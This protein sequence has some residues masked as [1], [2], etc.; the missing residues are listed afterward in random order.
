ME[1]IAC[2]INKHFPDAKL[3]GRNYFV[4]CFKCGGGERHQKSLVIDSS[5][6]QYVCNRKNNCGVSGNIWTLRKELGILPEKKYVSKPQNR[7]KAIPKPIKKEIKTQEKEISFFKKRNINPDTVKFFKVSQDSYNEKP[8]ILFPYYYHGELVN[9][10]Y[11]LSG[12]RFAQEKDPFHTLWNLDTVVPSKDLYIVEGEADAMSMWQSG[13][14]NV[15]SVPSGVSNLNWIDNNWDELEDFDTIVLAL[16]N[17]NAGNEAVEKISLRLG[18]HRCKRMIFKGFKDANEACM[19]GYDKCLREVIEV[20]E[21]R[22]DPITKATGFED[23]IIFMR[24]DSEFDVGFKSGFDIRKSDGEFKGFRRGA[25]TIWTGFE[26]RGKTTMVFNEMCYQMTYNSC[27]VCIASLETHPASWLEKLTKQLRGQR[28]T[29]E[30]IKIILRWLND[31]LSIVNFRG[32]IDQELLFECMEYSAKRY[33]TDHFVIDNL[34]RINL[35][36]RD[37]YKGHKEFINKLCAFSQDYG[38]HVHLV[39]HQRKSY[40]GNETHPSVSGILGSSELANAVDNVF[41]VRKVTDE[42]RTE[43][44]GDYKAVLRV[45]KQRE[46]G[47]NIAIGMYYFV[48]SETFSRSMK[49]DKTVFMKKIGESLNGCN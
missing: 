38:V 35:D 41:L 48:H 20:K 46:G 11:R 40:N 17:D 12:K 42:N 23:K 27:N 34:M 10:K 18:K 3:S 1:D 6:G 49:H 22:P 16:D 44:D 43:N 21:L 24:N 32:M 39:C 36:L 31:K 33:G 26:G 47:S 37:G 29:D 30:E 13:Y 9:I 4:E 28:C 25:T 2:I 5:T 19:A 7:V 8:A 15:V 14:K 45:G